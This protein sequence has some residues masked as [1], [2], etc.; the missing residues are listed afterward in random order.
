MAF[1]PPPLQPAGGTTVATVL[2]VDRV[3]GLKAY[4]KAERPAAARRRSATDK[5]DK[6]NR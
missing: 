6:S 5:A 1:I 4:A 2:P 3:A